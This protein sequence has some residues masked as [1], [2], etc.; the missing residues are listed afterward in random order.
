MKTGKKQATG[1]TQQQNGPDDY[2]YA[3]MKIIQVE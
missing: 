1:L 2:N 3:N